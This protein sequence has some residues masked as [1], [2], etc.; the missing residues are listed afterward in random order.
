MKKNLQIFI[1]AIFTLMGGFLRFYNN[2]GNPPSLSIDEVAYGYSAY[3]IL[4]TG[5]DE[6]GAFLPLT[7]KSVGD[8]KSPLLIYSLVP[9]IA[10]FGLNEFAVRFPTALIGTFSIPLFFL[11]LSQLLKNQKIA[12]TG[13]AL[14]AISPWHIY[15]S[16]YAHDHLL[17]TFLLIIGMVAFLKMLEGK[18]VW[19]IAAGLFLTLSLYAYHSEKIFIPLFILIMLI[20]NFRKLKRATLTLFLLTCFVLG[21]PLLYLTLFGQAGAR[22]GMVFLSQDI[23]FTRYVILDHLKEG[24]NE[25][26]MLF[27][28]WVKRYLNYFQPNFLF[29]NG[30]NMTTSGSLGLGVLYLFEL[31]WLILGIITLIKEKI[32]N[33]AL[34]ILWIFVG[35]IPASLANNEFSSSRNLNILPMLIVVVS[36]GALSFFRLI[37]NI[38]STY[39]KKGLFVC[40]GIFI[41]LM[42]IHAYLVFAVHF[43]I[44]RGEAF[45]EGTKETVI[46][47]L[48]HQAEYQEIVF[49]PRRGVEAGNI[50]S[51]PYMYILFYGKY[52]PEIFQKEIQN[53]DEEGAHF[54]KF[55][56]RPIDWRIDRSKKGVLFIGSPWHIPPQDIKENEIL[57]KIFLANGNLAFLIVS[58]KP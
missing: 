25:T 33:K 27:F 9:S 28:F 23:D 22:A 38:S 13:T 48:S 44:E 19:S 50:I 37:N 32:P 29:F 15:Y 17:A 1:I 30:L 8:Y 54:G 31:P 41:T 49:D 11:L 52:D 24:F 46:Y 2:T 55:T 26:L 20:L 34:I 57:Q 53:F 43:P 5:R 45:M 36:L 51:I 10:I 42:L 56:I 3:S 35:L 47:A 14:L 39:F 16:R 6:N 21:L 58:P 12:L 4:K 18:K 7:F 40:Y